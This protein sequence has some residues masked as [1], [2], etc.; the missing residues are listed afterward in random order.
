MIFPR[1]SFGDIVLLLLF[2]FPYLASFLKA[3]PDSQSFLF[4]LVNP[5]GD[6]PMKLT[7]K[8]DA[9][10]QCQ[11]VLGPAFGDSKCHDL[12]VWYPTY[13]SFLDLGF[14]FT[15]P[16]NVNRNTYFAGGS[17]FEVSELEVFKVSIR[18]TSNSL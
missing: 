14:G 13:G 9:A 10:I 12:I 3:I 1:K 15:C 7:S 17:P 6:E 4:T 5:S 18:T 8:P 2:C 16:E 11:S